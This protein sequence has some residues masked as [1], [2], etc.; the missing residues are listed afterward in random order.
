MDRINLISNNLLRIRDSIY[1]KVGKIT[2]TYFVSRS[3]EI[4]PLYLKVAYVLLMCPYKI[5]KNI[6]NGPLQ[7]SRIQKG[8]IP[9]ILF[10]LQAKLLNG[11]S[12]SELWVYFSDS[13][14]N[15]LTNSLLQ[16]HLLQKFAWTKYISFFSHIVLV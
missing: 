10:N 6:E 12:H 15:W 4:L 1:E 14:L 8:K 5:S 3:T 16:K 2:A 9:I 13:L 11:S 7:K